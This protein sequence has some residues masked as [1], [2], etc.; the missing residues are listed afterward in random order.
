[1]S[2]AARLR[3]TVMLAS[4]WCPHPVPIAAKPASQRP[5]ESPFIDVLSGIPAEDLDEDRAV[6]HLTKVGHRTNFSTEMLDVGNCPADIRDAYGPVRRQGRGHRDEQAGAVLRSNGLIHGK[7]LQFAISSKGKL[8]TDTKVWF[9]T[10]AGRVN[11]AKAA[12]AAGHAAVATGRDPAKVIAAV[13]NHDQLLAIKLDVTRPEDAVAAVEAAVGKLGRIDVLA[14]N[15]GNFFAGFFEELSSDQVRQ[16]IETLLFGPM[17]VRRAVLPVMRRQ[18]SGLLLTISSTAGISGGMFCTAYAAAKFGIEGWMESLAPEVAPFGTRTI[19]GRARI[20]PFRTAQ[21]RLDHLR[22]ACYRRLRRAHAGNCR[23]LEQHEG[24]QG[25]APAKLADALIHLT[26]L[27]E[28]PARFA[29]GADA[30]LTFEAKA[31]TLLARRRP[32]ASCPRHL[33]T[34]P[35]EMVRVADDIW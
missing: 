18:R 33:L 16:Q 20:L 3:E 7:Q 2:E 32:C 17:N 19:T 15:A 1:M 8:M 14:N 24:K 4:I 11:I 34:T 30:V 29:A 35:V 25:G 26:G 31:K 27:A 21:H 9:I 6:L 22:A 10:G 5:R 13:G 28:P 12:P 23:R